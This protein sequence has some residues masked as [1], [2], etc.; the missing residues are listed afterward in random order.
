[1]I[2][3]VVNGK[4]ITDY[5]ISIISVSASLL[6]ASKSDISVISADLLIGAYLIAMHIYTGYYR[7]KYS[8]P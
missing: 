3:R 4:T 5:V 6:V 8:L 2:I 1:M 7:V